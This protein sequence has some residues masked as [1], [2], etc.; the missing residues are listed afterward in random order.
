M[1][2]V[3]IV[4]LLRSWFTHITQFLMILYSK[5]TNTVLLYLFVIIVLVHLKTTIEDFY[6]PIGVGQRKAP[7]GPLWGM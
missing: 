4:D 1:T 3:R 2:E 5:P 6:H 7:L